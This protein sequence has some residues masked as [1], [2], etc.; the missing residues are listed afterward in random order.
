M[1]IDLIKDFYAPN[2]EVRIKYEEKGKQ[3]KYHII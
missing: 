1:L 2:E 3:Y